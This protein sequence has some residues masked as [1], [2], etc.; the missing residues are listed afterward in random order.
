MSLSFVNLHGEEI[1]QTKMAAMRAAGVTAERARRL[2][3][4]PTEKSHKGW[5]VTGIPPGKLEDAI[6]SHERLR[7][8]A[9]K[10]GGKPI[11]PF[12]ED[13]WLRKQ[14]RSAVRS[15]PYNL[16][17]AAHQCAEL[18]TKGGWVDVRVTE[19]ASK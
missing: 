18:A 10:T 16:Q 5:R 19:L 1:T 3:A 8:L 7:E 2:A 15:K 11:E 6:A 12:S 13:A 17:A 4:K 14:R 9:V